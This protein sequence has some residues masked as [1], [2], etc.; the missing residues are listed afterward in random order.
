[1]KSPWIYK[2]QE[3]R[4]TNEMKRPPEACAVESTSGGLNLSL[5][6]TATLG[7]L[8]LGARLILRCRKDWRD[9]TIVAVTTEAVTLSVFSPKGRTYRLR[10]PSD[11]PLAFDGSIPVLGEGHWRTG[12]ARYD[13]RW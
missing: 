1:L 6:E 5:T 12:L 9:A 7:S 10:R 4:V 11:S 2:Q 13:A 3:A 8:P